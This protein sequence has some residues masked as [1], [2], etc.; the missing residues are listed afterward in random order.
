[1]SRYRAPKAQLKDE[2]IGAVIVLKT[3]YQ[4]NIRS[5]IYWKARSLIGK[6]LLPKP[7]AYPLLSITSKLQLLSRTSGK[8]I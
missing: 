3:E 6:L 4:G 1:M 5:D 2:I 7:E 8:D